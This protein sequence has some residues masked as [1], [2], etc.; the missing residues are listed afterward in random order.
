M[1]GVQKETSSLSN[2]IQSLKFFGGEVLKSLGGMF[3]K[4]EYTSVQKLMSLGPCGRT[5]FMFSFYKD[6][7]ENIK[8]E[9]FL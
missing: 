1:L 6:H 3:R 9:F 7:K 8:M 2:F 4:L 5:E